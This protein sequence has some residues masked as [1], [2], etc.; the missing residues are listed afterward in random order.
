MTLSMMQ[1]T[2]ATL[3]QLNDIQRIQT[4]L[5]YQTSDIIG[6]LGRELVEEQE[7]K[8]SKSQSQTQLRAATLQA[9]SFQ[10]KEIKRIRASD[11]ETKRIRAFERLSTPG[12]P[13]RLSLPNDR[14]EQLVKAHLTEV[15]RIRASK[16]LADTHVA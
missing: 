12:H 1:I 13:E 5:G 16:R 6:K 9:A 14:S 2:L 7:E 3:A 11:N 8:I 4:T 15:K 10:A